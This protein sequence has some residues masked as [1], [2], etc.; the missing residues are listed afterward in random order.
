M[1]LMGNLGGVSQRFEVEFNFK[2]NLK[3]MESHL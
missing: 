2:L 1:Q 3:I